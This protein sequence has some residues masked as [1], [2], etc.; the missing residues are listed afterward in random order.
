MSS[1]LIMVL[2]SDRHTGNG[3]ALGF[4]N[5]TEYQLGLRESQ[6]RCPVAAQNHR[7]GALPREK[8]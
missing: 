5:I 2:L 1:V 4:L 7:E 3:F 8:Q 6:D